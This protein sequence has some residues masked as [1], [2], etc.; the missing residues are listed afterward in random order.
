MPKHDIVTSQNSGF[1]QNLL[2][3]LKLIWRLIG[4]PRVSLFLKLLPIASLVYLVSPV[5]LAPG[6]ALPF[7]GA[8]D[9][10][11]IVWIGTSLFLNLCPDHVVQEHLDSLKK[12]I[13]ATW[14]DAKP[15][16]EGEIVEVTPRDADE[17][18]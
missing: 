5:D 13:P 2:V 9:D 18:G 3:Q 17:N 14:R 6:L 16:E 11:A 15:E 10:A 1:F 7:I 4:D 12:V 8:L